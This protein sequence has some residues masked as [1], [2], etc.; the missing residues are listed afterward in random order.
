MLEAKWPY[1]PRNACDNRDACHRALRLHPTAADHI[2]N[3][4]IT[5]VRMADI[6]DSEGYIGTAPCQDFSKQ[7]IGGGLASARGFLYMLQF[8]HIKEI[9]ESLGK[10]LKWVFLER[11]G[12]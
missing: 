5:N 8:I 4:D 10:L 1:D 2:K 11:H 12:R 7:G 9:A 6:S 3:D